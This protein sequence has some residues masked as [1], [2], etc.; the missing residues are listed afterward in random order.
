MEH[1]DFSHADLATTLTDLK[2]D[3]DALRMLASEFVKHYPEQTLAMAGAYREGDLATLGKRLHQARGAIGIF[4]ANAALAVAGAL[5]IKA[6]HGEAISHSEFYG[7]L[8]SYMG[9]GLDLSL[10]LD[11]PN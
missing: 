9:L 7:F 6:M 11:Q 8:N 4:R 5:E 3:M 10:L 2:G 1:H